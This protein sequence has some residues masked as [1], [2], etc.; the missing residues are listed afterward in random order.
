M[1]IAQEEQEGLV[2]ARLRAAGFSNQDLACT[3]GTY[4]PD[5]GGNHQALAMAQRYA[6]EFAVPMG[7]GLLLWGGVGVGKSHLAASILRRVVERFELSSRPIRARKW[8]LPALLARGRSLFEDV[9]EM[10]ALTEEIAKLDIVWLDEFATDVIG[11][12]TYERVRAVETLYRVVDSIVE[13]QV[14]LVVTTNMSPEV[15]IRELGRLDPTR[16]VED[17]LRGYVVP[18]AVRGESYRLAQ[19]EQRL[20][21]W[22][23]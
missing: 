17:R 19:R 2:L 4:D 20:P 23:K 13:A 16:R 15:L 8:K 18:V 5:F 22:A 9:A 7:W 1:V 3:F 6:E 14:G 10:E 21:E 12:G 11:A